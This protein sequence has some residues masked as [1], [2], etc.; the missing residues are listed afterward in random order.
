MNVKP[1]EKRRYTGRGEGC[2]DGTRA[3]G[4]DQSR[5]YAWINLLNRNSFFCRTIFKKLLIINKAKYF[6]KNNN[7]AY[8]SNFK[9]CEQNYWIFSFLKY[10]NHPWATL[11]SCHTASHH[12]HSPESHK[13]KHCF[14]LMIGFSETGVDLANEI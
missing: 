9:I 1:L 13:I 14:L 10:S 11:K 2:S 3:N 12:S 8:I 5:L 4:N 7:K 6:H